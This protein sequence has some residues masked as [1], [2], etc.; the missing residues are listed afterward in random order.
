M[1]AYLIKDSIYNVTEITLSHVIGKLEII[2]TEICSERCW[3]LPAHVNKSEEGWENT[4]ELFA[5]ETASAVSDIVSYLQN[6]LSKECKEMV[7]ENVERRIFIPYFTSEIP[8]RN[9]EHCDHNWNAVCAG[10]IGSACI[11]L[12]QEQPER[13]DSYLQRICNALP[14]Y[15][16]GFADDGTCMEGLSYYFYGM[17]YFVNFAEDLYAYTKG[18]IDLLRGEWSSFAA[19]VADK[20]AY[21]ANWW[22]KCYFSSGMTVSFSDGSKHDKF[23]VGLALTLAKRFPGANVADFQ[24][25][26][27]F[28]GDHC[29]RY[30]PMKRT[31]LMLKEFKK[32]SFL[33]EEL[34]SFH[35]LP[36][37]QWCI[38]NSK[39]GISFACKAGHNDE[40]HNHNDIGS[41][42]YSIGDQVMLADLGAGEYTK[43]YFHE[44]RYT[45]LCNNSFGHSVPMIEGIGQSTGKQYAA[46][47]FEATKDGKVTMEFANAYEDDSLTE[48]KIRFHFQL[49]TRKLKLIDYFQTKES[50]VITENLI[51]Q[52]EPEIRENKIIL[53]TKKNV[54]EII[55]EGIRDDIKVI[56]KEHSNHRGI[57]EYVYQIQW[58]ISSANQSTMLIKSI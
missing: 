41:F 45:I 13:L 28:L 56:K 55:I 38:G 21:I 4:V 15:I 54:C 42:I 11:Y 43:D 27:K 1:L 2:L 33:K 18:K 39:N 16:D 49:E 29:Y 30:V 14:H 31:L 44:G 17:N 19:G 20:R 12:L 47:L 25:A 40:P 37:A 52:I 10:S 58:N 32:E 57:L 22:T 26:S 34:Q 48:L 9:W 6:E 7:I 35:V 5:S 24:Q 3:A 23:S 53:R 8:Y 50:C 46:S 51:T 36:D